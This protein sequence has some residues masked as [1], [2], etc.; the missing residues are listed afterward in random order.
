MLKPVAA[1][2]AFP[3]VTLRSES[4]KIIYTKSSKFFEGRYL[5]R[6]GSP[7]TIQGEL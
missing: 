7:S 2:R 3:N 6:T 4:V 5:C 1:P